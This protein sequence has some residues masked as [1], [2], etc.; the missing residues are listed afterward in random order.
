MPAPPYWVLGTGY[1]VLSTHSQR[2]A[3]MP[4]LLVIDDEASILHAFRRAFRDPELTLRTASTGAEGLEMAAG[5]RPDVVILD[6]Q[7]P[8]G[9]SH[10][11]TEFDRGIGLGPMSKIPRALNEWVSNNTTPTSMEASFA[12]SNGR[13]LPRAPERRQSA[14]DLF[15]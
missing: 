15:C 14:F 2:V 12:H 6:I 11:A 13:T 7:L 5:Q 8:E 4:V 9:G 3:A 1:W 10:F